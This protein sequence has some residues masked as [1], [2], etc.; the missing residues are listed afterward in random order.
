MLAPLAPFQPRRFC[1][2]LNAAPPAAQAAVCVRVLD[3]GGSGG[4][5]DIRRK[6][7]SHES[8]SFLRRGRPRGE[9]EDTDD[10]ELLHPGLEAAFRNVE[11]LEEEL[12]RKPASPPRQP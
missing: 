6:D 5:G 11:K 9:P 10:E 2:N 8:S 4:G 12:K 1:A 3:L 7:G